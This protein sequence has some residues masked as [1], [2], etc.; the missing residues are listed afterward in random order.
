[1]DKYSYPYIGE[2]RP[3]IKPFNFSGGLRMG[4]R[5]SVIC[6]VIDGDPPFK[7]MWLKDGKTLS[8]SSSVTIRTIDDFTSNLALTN[9]GPESN[10]NYTCRVSNQAGMDQHSDM[11]LMK[12]KK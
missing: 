8:E 10:G 11:L 4:K 6:A 9:L 1:M 3:E 2:S 5:T 7:F 12:S